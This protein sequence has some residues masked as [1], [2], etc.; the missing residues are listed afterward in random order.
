MKLA[1]K[2]GRSPEVT[3]KR[4]EA[5]LAALEEEERAKVLKRS[6]KVLKDFRLL[7]KYVECVSSILFHD[8]D[9]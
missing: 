3:M 8:N 7:L 5:G 1:T 4:I 2:L 9:R 6:H